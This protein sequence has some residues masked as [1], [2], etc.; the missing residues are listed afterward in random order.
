MLKEQLLNEYYYCKEIANSKEITNLNSLYNNNVMVNLPEAVND[1]V[2]SFTGNLIGD[3][4]EFESTYRL[5]RKQF[6]DNLFNECIIK[7]TGDVL[8]QSVDELDSESPHEFIKPRVRYNKKEY[9]IDDATE[10]VVD[11]IKCCLVE[12]MI[13]TI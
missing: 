7:A 8:I 13:R 10:E 3:I 12:E 4:G 5:V 11:E 6:K 9:S 1:K 2:Y